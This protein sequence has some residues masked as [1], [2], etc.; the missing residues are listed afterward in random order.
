MEKDVTQPK[1][2]WPAKIS[3]PEEQEHILQGHGLFKA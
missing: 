2:G 1:S 3:N